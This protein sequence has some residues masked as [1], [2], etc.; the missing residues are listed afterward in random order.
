MEPIYDKDK[1]KELLK[2]KI[3]TE[4]KELTPGEIKDT[5]HLGFDLGVDSFDSIIISSRLEAAA[6]REISYKD[7]ISLNMHTVDEAADL[8]LKY[9]IP[10]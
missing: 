7:S 10:E 5:D 6:G 2:E 3:C 8:L 4:M 9:F 1:V